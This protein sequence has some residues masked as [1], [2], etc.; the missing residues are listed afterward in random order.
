[1]SQSPQVESQ[2]PAWAYIG[3]LALIGL[4]EI[5]IWLIGGN[6]RY[7]GLA[8]GVGLLL[9]APYGYYHGA[10][11]RRTGPRAGYPSSRDWSYWLLV[12]GTVLLVVGL[13]L[14]CCGL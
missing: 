11:L 1:M 6:H 4:I 8:F 5:G 3:A 10:A 12:V 13:V 9:S 2:K 7:S 14:L